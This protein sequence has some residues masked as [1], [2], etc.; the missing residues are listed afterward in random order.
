MSNM[1]FSPEL[2]HLIPT[3]LVYVKANHHLIPLS[4][5]IKVLP[6]DNDIKVS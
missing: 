3:F 4:L 6:G 1:K 5:R 2:V